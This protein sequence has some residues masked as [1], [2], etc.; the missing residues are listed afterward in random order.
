MVMIDTYLVPQNTTVN[1]KGDGEVVEVSSAT[2]RTFLL[3]L[4]V[5]ET[6]EQ[7]SLD[8]SVFGSADGTTWDPKPIISF[9]QKFYVGETPILVE[10][11]ST[12]TRFLRAHWEVN[13]WGRGPE[14]PMFVF[15]VGIKEVPAEVLAEARAHR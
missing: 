14:Q 7:E 10:S 9:P 8:V 2:N 12:D 4:R 13:R 6:V 5:V 1:A 11:V 3:T 15:D